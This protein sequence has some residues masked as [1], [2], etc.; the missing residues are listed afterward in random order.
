MDDVIGLCSGKFATQPD[1]PLQQNLTTQQEPDEFSFPTKDAALT[2][3]ESQDTVIL[4]G[5][6]DKI[7]SSYIIFG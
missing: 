4:T 3:I 7:F 1:R 2:S 6:G 5:E